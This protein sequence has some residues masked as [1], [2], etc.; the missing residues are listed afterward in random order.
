MKRLITAFAVALTFAAAAEKPPFDLKQKPQTEEERQARI[1]WFKRQQLIHTGGFVVK[2]G[3]QQGEVVY[4]NCQKRAQLAWM[5][6]SAEYFR[7]ESK[8]KITVRDGGAFDLANPKVEGSATLFVVDDAKLPPILLAPE[9]RWAMVNVAGLSEGSGAKPAFFEARVKKSLTRGFA[10]LCG[11]SNSQYPMCLT[12]GITKP[13]DMDVMAD[14]RLQA[15]VIERFKTYMAPFGVKPAEITTYKRAC[16]Q[17]WA[18]AP[19]NEIQ[20]AIWDEVHA[21]PANPIK[22]KPETKKVSD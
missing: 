8:F 13:S 16:Q 19:T 2:P 4:L 21:L 14:L 1:A 20:K 15:D 10:L 22:I 5:E 17:G 9:S 11:A 6:E 3:T 18:S 7:R 12:G